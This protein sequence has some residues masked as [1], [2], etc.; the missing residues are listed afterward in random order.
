MSAS[1]ETSFARALLD[2]SPHGVHREAPGIVLQFFQD[3]RNR[4]VIDASADV[5]DDRFALRTNMPQ[6]TSASLGLSYRKRPSMKSRAI[7][8][9]SLFTELTPAI[10]LSQK[11]LSIAAAWSLEILKEMTCS[12]GCHAGVGLDLLT[13]SDSSVGWPAC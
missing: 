2:G 7:F 5:G 4:H 8:R 13:S 9:A 10:A 1:F 11:N 6:S 3:F 12:R